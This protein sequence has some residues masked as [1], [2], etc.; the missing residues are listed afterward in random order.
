MTAALAPFIASA[1]ELT[2][3]VDIAIERP[4]NEHGDYWPDVAPDDFEML[5]LI[6][7]E[8]SSS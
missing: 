8:P 1:Q 3:S 5:A 6:V 2:P 4:P 7:S